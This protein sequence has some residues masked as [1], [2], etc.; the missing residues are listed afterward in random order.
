MIRCANIVADMIAR[1]MAVREKPSRKPRRAPNGYNK[2]TYGALVANDKRNGEIADKNCSISKNALA[3]EVARNFNIRQETNVANNRKQGLNNNGKDQTS[4]GDSVPKSRT[5][6]HQNDIQ[7]GR[8][9]GSNHYTR[10]KRRSAWS[11]VS[12]RY[13]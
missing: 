7:S 3:K 4:N 9:S 12:Y 11:R 8:S 2:K 13:I 1:D 10:P 6:I 5:V